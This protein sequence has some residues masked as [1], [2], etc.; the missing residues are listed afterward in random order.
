MPT[1]S[2]PRRDRTCGFGELL[3]RVVERLPDTRSLAYLRLVA[4]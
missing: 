4:V 3:L 1:L 2:A